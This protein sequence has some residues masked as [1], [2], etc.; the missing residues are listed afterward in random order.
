MN[1]FSNMN[2][3]SGIPPVST[4][5]WRINK[6]RKTGDKKGRSGKEKK[7]DKEDDKNQNNIH[8]S[9]SKSN[10]EDETYCEDQAGYGVTGKKKTRCTKIDL[11]I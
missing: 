2:G 1:M 8:A 6:K 5:V 10:T 11:E 3:M 4:G 7:K 9:E